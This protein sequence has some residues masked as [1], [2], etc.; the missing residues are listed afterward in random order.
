MRNRR[1]IFTKLVGISLSIAASVIAILAPAA[2]CYN[3]EEHKIMADIGAAQVRIPPGVVLPPGVQFKSVSHTDY[4]RAME[5][6]KTLA[7]GFATNNESDYDQ[8]KLKVQDNYYHTRFGQSDYNLKLWI[9]P[10]SMAPNRV[11]FVPTRVTAE[12]EPFSF[13]ELV[14]FYGDYRRTVAPSQSG[15]CY[16]SNADLAK[17]EFKRGDESQKYAPDPLAASTYLRSIASGLVP[18]YGVKGNATG[19]TAKNLNDYHEGGWWGD[20]MMRVAAINDWHFANAAFAWYV[21]LHRLALVY[22]EQAQRNPANWSTALHLEACAL[23]T[24]TDLFS[25]GHIVVSRD[26]TS[27]KTSKASGTVTNPT[28]GWMNNAISMGGGSRDQ[29]GIVKLSNTLPPISHFVAPRDNQLKWSSGPLIGRASGYENSYHNQFNASGAV[30]RNLNGDQFQIYGDFKLRDTPGNTRGIIISTVRES[31]QSLF[32]AYT[33]LQ[34]RRGTIASIGAPGS[35]YFRALKLIPVWVEKDPDDFFPG[36][37]TRYA[38]YADKIA[39]TKKVPKEWEQCVMPYIDGYEYLPKPSKRKTIEV[40]SAKVTP[41]SGNTG[42]PFTLTVD[43]AIDGMSADEKAVVEESASVSG[44]LKMGTRTTER[45]V[46]SADRKLTQSWPY[47]PG[48]PGNYTFSYDLKF[49]CDTKSGGVPFYVSAAPKPAATSTQPVSTDPRK[50]PTTLY[51]IDPPDI[52]RGDHSNG[53]PRKTAEIGTSSFTLVG[54][55]TSA[56]SGIVYKPLRTIVSFSQPPATITTGQE[57]TLSMKLN[58]DP[59]P[60]AHGVWMVGGFKRDGTI[61][62]VEKTFSMVEG[63]FTDDGTPIKWLPRSSSVFESTGKALYDGWFKKAT[64]TAGLYSQGGTSTVTWRYEPKGGVPNEPIKAPPPGGSSFQSNVPPRNTPPLTAT[65]SEVPTTSPTPVPSDNVTT[66]IFTTP[67]SATAPQASAQDADSPISIDDLSGTWS[68]ATDVL[69]GSAWNFTKTGEGTYD[70]EESGLGNARGKVVVQ[71][72]IITLTSSTADGAYQGTYRWQLSDDLKQGIGK[73]TFSKKPAGDSLPMSM[74][75]HL[76]F[77]SR[78][79]T[80]TRRA[81]RP[82]RRSPEGSQETGWGAPIGRAASSNSQAPSTPQAT[83]RQSS[84]WSAMSGSG[85]RRTGGT[86]ISGTWGHKI[87]RLGNS[88]WVFTKT[89]EDTYFAQEKGLGN[90]SGTAVL[91]GNTLTV[92]WT[93]PKG[94]AGYYQWRLSDDL[95]QGVGKLVFT[96]KP[97]GDGLPSTLTSNLYLRSQD[98]KPIPQPRPVP[99]QRSIPVPQQHSSPAPA[100]EPRAQTPV[101]QEPLLGVWRQADGREARWTVKGDTYYCHLTRLSPLLVRCRFQVGE[102]ISV[103]KRVSTNR[104]RGQGLWKRVSPPSA[105]WQTGAVTVSGDRLSDT[106]GNNLTRVGY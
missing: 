19:Y 32:D 94:L 73:M 103:M 26:R 13:G 5:F 37:W 93:T 95:T 102:C 77:S 74:V 50:T 76:Y 39:G 48:K 27:Y 98:T 85:T 62:S 25:F 70:A 67:E 21:G 1:D 52:V 6:A 46:T 49:K 72:N 60:R 22:V 55:E 42:T 8:W 16:F 89:A 91:E 15:A 47:T 51:R 45:T 56:R 97:A 23:H 63:T 96:K 34:S 99:Q 38:G 41:T 7:V 82:P 14:S 31:L 20:E 35:S 59:G 87:E 10:A 66:E 65:P 54:A 18:P 53:D 36:K 24:L 44:S 101:A 43:Y 105:E 40:L 84:G 57:I 100:V 80:G 2:R 58:P 61:A 81:P 11:L 106:W 68:Q 69:G 29:Q 17:I 9:P 79:K 3:S 71:G 83:P 33:Q 28:V 30:V 75:S 92:N 4:I 12:D 90:A 88:A 104:F 86:D 64:I 78:P